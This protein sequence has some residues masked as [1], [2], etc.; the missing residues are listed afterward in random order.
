MSKEIKK[1]VKQEVKEPNLD[2]LREA[3]K[4]LKETSAKELAER[5]ALIKTLTD[6]VETLKKESLATVLGLQIGDSQNKV[7][8]EVDDLDLFRFE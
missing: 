3:V 7:E 2:E 8:D 6:E 5:D 4:Q 1:E